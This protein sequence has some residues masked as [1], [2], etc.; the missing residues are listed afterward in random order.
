MRKALPTCRGWSDFV[1]TWRPSDLILVTRKAPRDQAQKLLFERHQKAFPDE[2]FPLLYR[3]RDT[4]K[5]NVLVTIPGPDAAKE[6]LVLNDAVEVSVETAQEVL[7]GKW[8]HDWALG[9]ALMVHSSQGLTIEDPQKVWIIDDYLQW[10]NLAYL[11]VS[12]VRYLHQLARCCPPPDADSPPPP[13]YDEAT[14]RKNVGRKLQAYKRVDAAKGLKNDLR[15]RDVF[16]LK[17]KSSH[18]ATCNTELLWCYVP[19]DTRQVSIDRI[20]NTRG[21]T[22]DNVRLTCLEC[23]RKRGAAALV[24]TVTDEVQELFDML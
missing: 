11:A 7:D 19:K 20:D 18:C 8:G 14:A 17:E 12:R 15:M 3:P 23:N 4:R 5:Q 22:R 9:Y 1:N 10:S 21:H 2:T 16:A 13:V 6:E 24:T